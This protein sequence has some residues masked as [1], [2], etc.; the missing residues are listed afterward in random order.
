MHATQGWEK[1]TPQGGQH[2]PRR[3]A[4]RTRLVR[5]WRVRLLCP[6]DANR[7]R[8]P[9]VKCALVDVPACARGPT[10]PLEHAGTNRTSC[11]ALVAFLVLCFYHRAM[12]FVTDGLL[13]EEELSEVNGARDEQ[14]RSDE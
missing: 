7:N 13:A 6:S 9:L 10:L 14:V 12:R 5:R 1:A 11:S 8:L 4:A 3:A 2:A